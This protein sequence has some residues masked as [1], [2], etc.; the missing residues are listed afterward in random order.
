MDTKTKIVQTALALFN[1]QGVD[2]ITVRHIA[3]E[4]G[5]SHGNLCYHF[6]N[7]DT[8]IRQLYDQLVE[9]LTSQIGG[10]ITGPLSLN[11]L[12]ELVG[13]VMQMLYDYRFLM[14]DFAGIMRRIPDLR[15][16][17]RALVSSRKLAFQHILTQLRALGK[18][19]EELYDGHDDDLLEQFFIVGDFWLSSATILYE[20]AEENKIKHY[21][22][23]F[24]SLIVPCLTNKGLTEWKDIDR[25][26]TL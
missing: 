5:I 20:G 19:R 12:A 24:L 23:V 17:H 25:K 3:K 16:K 11:R 6:P 10:V 26:K 1:E 4:M 2:V 13:E 14:L 22:Q 18:L 21:Q 15:D 7:T 9:Q 8:I